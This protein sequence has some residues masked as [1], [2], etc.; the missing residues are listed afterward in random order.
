M[1]SVL[2]L[3]INDGGRG[4]NLHRTSLAINGDV[5]RGPFLG[6]RHVLL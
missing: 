5:G 4:D 6:A 1:V 3:V 2:G